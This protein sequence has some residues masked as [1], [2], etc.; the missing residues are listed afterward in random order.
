MHKHNARVEGTLDLHETVN[1]RYLRAR[2]CMR[3]SHV[4]VH[5]QMLTTSLILFNSR[6]N[7]TPSVTLFK[8]K[9]WHRHSRNRTISRPST[10]C[11]LPIG[12]DLPSIP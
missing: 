11:I 6:P 12:L 3:I 5:P 1:A 10:P 9:Y 7:T 8:S 4:K 2:L